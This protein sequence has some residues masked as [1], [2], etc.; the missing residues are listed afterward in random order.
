[1]KM[2]KKSISKH[3]TENLNENDESEINEKDEETET[4][5]DPITNETKEVH[6]AII[7]LFVVLKA[8]KRSKNGYSHM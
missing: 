5:D 8:I 7:D 6:V 4:L 3:L 1:M 2:R